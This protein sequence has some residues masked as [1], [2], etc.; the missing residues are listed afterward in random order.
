MAVDLRT[1]SSVSPLLHSSG[2]LP[3]GVGLVFPQLLIKTMPPTGMS[4]GQPNIGSP[5]LRLA[6]LVTLGSDVSTMLATMGWKTEDCLYSLAQGVEAELPPLHSVPLHTEQPVHLPGF[7][8]TSC[9]GCYFFFHLSTRKMRFREFFNWFVQPP[10]PL[11][12]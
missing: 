9:V 4:T 11:S 3:L 5:S 6:S 7:I 1:L 8:I 10:I 12:N 2:P